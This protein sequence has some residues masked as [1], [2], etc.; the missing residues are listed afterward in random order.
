M[1]DSPSPDS[2]LLPS[3]F[4]GVAVGEAF[5]PA[6]RASQVGGVVVCAGVA[7]LLGLSYYFPAHPGLDIAA[8]QSLSTLAWPAP[9]LGVAL[10]W[11]RR[12]REWPI[13]LLV[14]ATTLAWVGTT[15]LQAQAFDPALVALGLLGVALGAWLGRRWIAPDGQLDSSRRL[16]LFTL[17]LPVALSLLQSVLMSALLWWGTEADWAAQW[18]RIY[19]A[20]AMA[21]LTL[22]PALLTWDTAAATTVFRD[23]GNW[24]PI[25]AAFACMGLALVP[26]MHDEVIRAALTL[27]LCWAAVRSGMVL[28][29]QLNAAITIG[30]I[31]I[32]LAGFGPYVEYGYGIWALQVDLIGIAVLS[33]LLAVTIGER[34]RL[35]ARL[36]QARRFESLG[37]LAGG[38]AHDFNNVL[39]TIRACAEIASERMPPDSPGQAELAQLERATERGMDMT[40]Q[41]LLAARQ[42]DPA[43]SC[44]DLA[45]LVDEVLEMAR[46]L[47]PSRIQLSRRP[48]PGAAAPKVLANRGQLLRAVQNLLRNAIQAARHGVTLTVGTHAAGVAGETRFDLQLGDRQ[49]ELGWVEVADD[50]PGIEAVHWP[51]LF[52]PFYS[53]RLAQ[54]GSGLGL[55]IVAGV[56]SGHRGFVG[57]LTAPGRGTVFHLAVPVFDGTGPAS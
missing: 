51:H 1:K 50:G 31:A 2:G 56:A 3:D 22:V 11:R 9:A 42:G 29:A 40:Q 43:R 38:V 41:I 14:A 6:A 20:H 32:T 36:D 4:C 10:L 57:M 55:A 37:F 49:G 35:A 8:S 28:V 21:M 27:P 26:R 23:R 25:L 18:P 34:Q 12:V 45:E 19:V 48:L 53:T 5:G 46:P 17:L 44:V 7:F 52:D 39:G 24:L 15:S 30:M 33:L 13:Y 47:C 54:G 16:L